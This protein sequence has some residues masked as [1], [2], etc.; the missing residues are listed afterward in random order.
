M[1]IR[2]SKMLR[3]TFT[4][5]G[6]LISL[7]GL[8]AGL[9]V[10]IGFSLAQQHFGLS[11]IHISKPDLNIF[12]DVPISFCESKLEESRTGSDRDYLHGSQ[13]IHEADI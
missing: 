11:L 13:D 3:R 6:W 8:A 7:L 9:V 5:E 2:D 1:C 10:G 4:L 12:L